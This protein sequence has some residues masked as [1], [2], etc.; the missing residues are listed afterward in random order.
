MDI[1]L[2]FWAISSPIN[3]RWAPKIAQYV[4]GLEKPAEKSEE[5]TEL[6]VKSEN[7]IKAGSNWSSPLT[8]KPSFP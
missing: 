4:A 2:D 5:W 3:F 1:H 6:C 8:P 7:Q